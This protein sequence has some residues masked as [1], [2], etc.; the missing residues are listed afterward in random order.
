MMNS[1]PAKS[2]EFAKKIGE[3]WGDAG[4]SDCKA[5]KD[6]IC[7]VVRLGHTTPR[8]HTGFFTKTAGLA[9][10]IF[11]PEICWKESSIVLLPNNRQQ[12]Q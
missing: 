5:Y 10:V 3:P 4:G 2:L 12:M 11:L 8:L 1:L 6:G 9:I 7:A